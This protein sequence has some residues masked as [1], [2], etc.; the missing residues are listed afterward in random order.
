VTQLVETDRLSLPR[1]QEAMRRYKNQPSDATYWRYLVGQVPPAIRFI[2]ER[3]ELAAAL[4]ADAQA[5]AD[6]S[7]V[8]E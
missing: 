4:A 7:D 6:Q 3:P 1:F 5:L 8:T 2:V